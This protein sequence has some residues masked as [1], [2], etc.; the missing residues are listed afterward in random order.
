MEKIRKELPELARKN[1]LREDTLDLRKLDTKI[2]LDYADKTSDFLK[3]AKI[4]PKNR[5]SEFK[6]FNLIE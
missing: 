3:T 5:F 2:L 4:E 6:K 1:I